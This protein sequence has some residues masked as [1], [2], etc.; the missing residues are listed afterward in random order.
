MA[1]GLDK[2]N[3]FE[4]MEISESR[5]KRMRNIKGGSEDSG[6]E[7]LFSDI[8]SVESS[9]DENVSA[10]GSV[11]ESASKDDVPVSGSLDS[12]QVAKEAN[13]DFVFCPVCPNRKFLT[14]KDME[15][16]M[17]SKKHIKREQ[18][19]LKTPEVSTAVPATK[20]ANAEPKKKE[21]QPKP[22]GEPKMNRRTRRA[23]LARTDSQ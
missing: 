5:I 11:D 4:N 20:K 23:N 15:D 6:D 19:L 10:D 2:W 13:G 22:E 7:E 12:G 1:I 17:K 21:K 8:D 18:A 16:H 9:V 3:D 14:E